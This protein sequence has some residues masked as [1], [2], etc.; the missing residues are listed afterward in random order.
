VFSIAGDDSVFSSA[1]VA[2]V[3]ST[4]P[5]DLMKPYSRLAIVQVQ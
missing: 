4:G 5:R 3:V 2:V 1:R